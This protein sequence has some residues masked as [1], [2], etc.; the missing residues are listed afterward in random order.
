MMMKS[1][2]RLQCLPSGTRRALWRGV[3]WAVA[4]AL[5]DGACGLLLVPLI[6]AWF[7]GAQAAVLHWTIALGV[8]TLCHAFVLYVAQRGGYRAGGALAAGLVERLVR[9]LPPYRVVGRPC[10]TVIRP[11]CCAGRSCRRWG[12]RRTCSGR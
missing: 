4:A 11:G 9:H 7:A 12:F 2:K 3:G 1:L 8:L 6:R 5:L 10:A